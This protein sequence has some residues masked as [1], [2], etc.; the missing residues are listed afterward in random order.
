MIFLNPKREGIRRGVYLAFLKTAVR[1]LRTWLLIFFLGIKV[2][3]LSI[4]SVLS[5]S[6][7][8]AI[9]PIPAVIGSHEIVQVFVFGALGLETGKG[10]TFTM[11]IRGV[12]VIVALGGI[13]ILF[14]LGLKL[15]ESVLSKNFKN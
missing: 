13:I 10:I 4:L 1:Y 3:F 2:E 11:V 9:I 14:R 12:E 15:L 8:A 7:L 6:Y 5:F